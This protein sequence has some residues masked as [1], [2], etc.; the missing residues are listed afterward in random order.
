MEIIN[1]LVPIIV[2]LIMFYLGIVEKRLSN[3]QAKLEKTV[4]RDEVHKA[5]E[6]EIK[7]VINEQVNLKEDLK[8]I[9]YKV[10]KLLDKF[11]K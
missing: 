10:D 8:R 2:T 5:V 7:A 6:L 3:M 11:V 1:I 9:E 4:E